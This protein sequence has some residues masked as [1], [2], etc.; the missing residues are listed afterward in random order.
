MRVP[1]DETKLQSA[2]RR[3][4]KIGQ[5]LNSLNDAFQQKTPLELLNAF[6]SFKEAFKYQGRQKLWYD[7][8]R[9]AELLIECNHFTGF[10]EFIKNPDYYMQEGMFYGTIRLLSRTIETHFDVEIRCNAL[11][12]LTQLWQEQGQLE[13]KIIDKLKGT[14]NEYTMF[15]DGEF[16]GR[17]DGILRW[18]AEILLEAARNHNEQL[19]QIAQ[20]QLE[21]LPRISSQ[22]Q[23]TILTEI[24]PRNYQ[25]LS[26]L[27]PID[28]SWS[29]YLLEIA[30]RKWEISLQTGVDRI[31]NGL[32]PLSSEWVREGITKKIQELRQKVL[33]DPQ[34][35]KELATYIPIRGSYNLAYTNP[36]NLKIKTK[37]FLSSSDQKVLLLLGSGG[38]G[39]STFNHY[40]HKI[41]WEEYKDGDP[42][43]LFIPLTSLNNPE[44][45]LL[46]EYLK[47]FGYEGLSF[48][49]QEIN[50]IKEQY[51]LTL[52]LDG[53]DEANRLN[54]KMV[55][56]YKSNHLD[57]WKV[58][59]IITCRTDYLTKISDSREAFMPYSRNIKQATAFVEMTVVPFT[60]EQITDYITQYLKLYREEKN[61][62]WTV[63]EYQKH[64]DTIP[65]LK[66]LI[67]TPFLL[68][69][70]MEELPR[71]VNQYKEEEKKQVGITK[72]QL[73]ETFIQHLFEREKEKL[74]TEGRLSSDDQY[75][76][77]DFWGFAMDL[78]IDM[79]KADTYQVRQGDKIWEEYFGRKAS[80]EEGL[81]LA[82]QGCLCILRTKT[83]RTEEGKEEKSYKFI[84]ATLQEHLIIRDCSLK[85]KEVTHDTTL[86]PHFFTPLSDQQLSST[87]RVPSCITLFLPEGLKFVPVPPDGH[88]LYNAVALYLNEDVSF[89]RDIVAANL[90]HNID[91][92]RPFITLPPG[93]TIEEYIKDIRSTNEWAGD[94]EITI[95]NRLLDRTIITIGPN[96]KITNRQVLDERR[97]GEPIF[98][99]YDNINHYDGMVLQGR[100]TAREILDNLLQET[101]SEMRGYASVPIVVDQPSATETLKFRD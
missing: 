82:R 69:I 47:N 100:Y 3:I 35:I 68:M 74:A 67:K 66:N 90:E 92:Y 19:R 25:K 65:G 38:G 87:F 86:Q 53:Y 17:H 22:F 56:F 75:I 41:L 27:Q 2:I 23:Q 46:P 11:K 57:S 29:V 31:E 33:T 77:D 40:L 9:Y 8:L 98:V 93:R 44:T 16:V 20:E 60:P 34:I 5:G 50:L 64:I 32:R 54:S 18:I 36:F 7:T 14:V 81:V 12:L 55:N 37:E 28:V 91:E 13:H 30:Q 1:D 70:T 78:A 88:C 43:V 80:K 10:E 96:G 85:A 62:H 99:Y 97:N 39:K 71:I 76:I 84:H 15:Q 94:L 21:E 89:L 79:G 51:S 45:E 95:L 58:K 49:D 24:I 4:I 52:I 59:V 73:L 6:I 83:L 42:I 63:E 101:Q 48:T 72:A 26:V 61:L